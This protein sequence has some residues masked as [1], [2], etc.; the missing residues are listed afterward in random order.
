MTGT[1]NGLFDK[2]EVLKDG[3]E[4][5]ACFV[6]KPETDDAALEALRTYANTT[7]DLQLRSELRGWIMAIEEGKHDD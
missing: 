4:Q 2:Y 5:D 1:D 6:L 3:E 7:E